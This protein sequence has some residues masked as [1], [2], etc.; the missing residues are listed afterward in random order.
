MHGVASRPLWIAAAIFL[1]VS[2]QACA[3]R[4]TTSGALPSTSGSAPNQSPTGPLSIARSARKIRELSHVAAGAGYPV[5]ADPP[6]PHPNEAPCVDKLFNPHTPPLTP[7]Q[8]PVGTFGDYSDHPFNYAPPANCPGP[9][10]KIVMKVDFSVSAGVQFDRTGAIWIGATNVFF[11][12]TAE[13]GQN[14]SPHWRV[15]RDV[16]EYAPIFAQPS[17]GQA[18]VY[19]V[20]NTQYTGII[21]GTAELDFYP[22]NSQFPAGRSA[23][24]VYPLSGGPNGGYVFL[25]GPSNQL[26]GSFT[27]PNNV[28]EAYLDLFLESQSNDEFWYS[29]FPNDLATK[30]GNCGGTGFR[31]G[32][33]TVDGQPAGVA[34]IFPWV[35]SGGF[36]PYLWVPVP[37]VQ[38]LNFKPYR[39][40]LTPF[41]A[42]FDDGN[43]HTIAIAVFNDDDYFATNGTLLVYTDHGSAQVSGG[44]ISNGTAMSPNQS[45]VEHVKVLPSGNAKGTID[46]SATHPVSLNGYVITSKGRVDTRVTQNIAFSNAQKIDVTSGEYLQ[47]ITQLTTVTSDTVTT[48][49]GGRLTQHSAQTWPF[50]VHYLYVSGPSGT[51]TQNVSIDQTENDNGLDVRRGA[52][53]SWML[54]NSM[55]SSD[56][57]NF[58]SGGF[59]PS[60]GK[61]R[62]QYK[63]LNVDDHCYNKILTTLNYVLTGTILGC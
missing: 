34:P 3:G 11:G 37:G 62:Q 10:A 9:Y 14:A 25:N 33:V 21:Y 12:T 58:T 45:V 26:T 48:S 7:G 51:A 6:V 50:G 35:Y 20:V 46:V 52:G 5:T 22:A 63:S 4:G 38:T 61:S 31:E 30:L 17:T 16:T 59:T 56:T 2:L 49:K 1:A 13:P 24:D 43:P 18:S 40:D 44:L 19:N 27:F 15:E 54:A 28:D 8:S 39:V 23:D 42:S 53:R 57:L 29:C 36:D 41:A 47:N 60:N 32:E 55:H